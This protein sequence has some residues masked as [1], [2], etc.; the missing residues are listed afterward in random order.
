MEKITEK[1]FRDHGWKK[2]ENWSKDYVDDNTIHHNLQY[3][4]ETDEYKAYWYMNTYIQPA[5]RW[6]KKKISRFYMFSA[7]GKNGFRAEN[8]VS[9]HRYALDDIINALRMVGCKEV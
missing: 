1:W 4:I 2:Y 7:S 6:D 5:T 8:R 3:Y 9:H